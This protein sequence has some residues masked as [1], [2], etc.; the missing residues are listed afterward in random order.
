LFLDNSVQTFVQLLFYA[1]R[2]ALSAAKKFGGGSL[3]IIA[4]SSE[5]LERGGRM[6]TVV[7]DAEQC[8]R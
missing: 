4:S 6:F 2:Y 7:P 8:K 1:F 3:D 5:S